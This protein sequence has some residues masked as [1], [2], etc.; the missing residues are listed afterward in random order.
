MNNSKNLYRIF[1]LLSVVLLLLNDLYLKYEFHNTLTGKLSDFAGL[2]AFPYFFSCFFPRRSFWVYVLT[3]LL[4]VF[5]KSHLSQFLIDFTQANN[6]WIDRT[7]DYT[8]LFSLI[9]LPISYFYW[10]SDITKA[11]NDHI[12]FKPLIIGVC[13]YS[14]IATSMPQHY[15]EKKLYSGYKVEVDLELDMVK[16]KLHMYRDNIATLDYYSIEFPE[17][18]AYISASINATTIGQQTTAITLDSIFSFTVKGSG[19]I[20]GGGV[21]ENNVNYM[22]NL[23]L[24][25]LEDRFKK[26]IK[27]VLN[28]KELFEDF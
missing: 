22:K 3:G 21:D 1:F 19:F 2:F 17:R 24:K 5:W 13:C 12:Y 25:E 10:K 20:F 16:S 11:V 28:D 9:I 23:S 18:N 27:V 26:Q 14:F 15:E 8:D 6:I 4:F 7:I